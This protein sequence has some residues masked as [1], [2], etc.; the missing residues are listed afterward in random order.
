MSQGA[1]GEVAAEIFGD[2]AAVY[3]W[4][5]GRVHDDAVQTTGSDEVVRAFR[6]RL[7]EATQ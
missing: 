5:W 4:L 3:L 1:E 2:P 7:T 6:G